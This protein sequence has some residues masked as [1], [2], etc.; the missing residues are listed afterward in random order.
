[1]LEILKQP[2]QTQNSYGAEA[3]TISLQLLPLKLVDNAMN[4]DQEFP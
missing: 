1:L 4:V 3:I 2:F